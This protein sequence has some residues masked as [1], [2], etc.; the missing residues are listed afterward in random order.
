MT[1]DVG[2]LSRLKGEGFSLQEISNITD[3]PKSTVRDRLFKAGVYLGERGQRQGTRLPHH[4]LAL[5]AFLYDRMGWSTTEVGEHF[6]INH[7]SVC[8]RLDQA[9]VPRRTRGESARLRF[10]RRPKRRSS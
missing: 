5:T 1:Y 2:D 6:G 8:W 4:E 3:I 10:A 7:D 9:G